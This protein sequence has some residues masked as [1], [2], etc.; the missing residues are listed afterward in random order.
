M[1]PEFTQY[2]FL[3]DIISDKRFINEVGNIFTEVGVSSLNPSLNTFLH[4]KNLS[5]EKQSEQIL[6]FRRDLMWSVIWEPSNY[7]YLLES[8]YNINSKIAGDDA[9]NLYPSD[10]PFDWKKADSLYYKTTI[11]PLIKDRDSVIASQIIRQLDAIRKSSSKH[12]KALVIM[13]YRHAF[14]NNFYTRDGKQIKNV[15]LFLFEHYGNKTV[16][17]LLN[18]NGWDKKDNALLLQQGKWDAAFSATGNKSTGFNL[19]NTP[20]GKDSFDLWVPGN[21]GFTYQDVFTGLVFYN[22]IEAQKL[23]TGISGFIDSAYLDEF[24]RRYQLSR[25]VPTNIKQLTDEEI[26]QL[27]KNSQDIERDINGKKVRQL[28]NI[29][30]LIKT[31]NVWLK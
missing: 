19:M 22:P 28:P 26:A 31:R 5:K 27:K 17:I 6:N 15:A 30:S 21:A 11:L 2:E 16:N 29:D 12:K 23:I 8:L 4:T 9:V 25:F 3:L 7:T 18:C 24:F 13:N 20:F 14:N 10:I 1:H